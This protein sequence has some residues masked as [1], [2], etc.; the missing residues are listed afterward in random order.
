MRCAGGAHHVLLDHNGAEIVGTRMKAELGDVFTHRQPAGLDIFN[1][2][3]H[4]PA[5]GD[6]ADIFFWGGQVLHAADLCKQGVNVLKGPGD[7]GQEAL[8]FSRFFALYVADL[9][10]VFKPFFDGFHVTKHHGGRGGDVQL[11]CLVHDVK[12]FLSTA[13]S[14]GDQPANPIDQNLR[15]STRERVEPRFFQRIEHF[16]MGGFLQFGDMC[17]FGRTEGMEL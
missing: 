15:T 13:F 12:P 1:I 8:G 11:V 3:Q 2:G 10:E 17:H 16:F 14:L 6:H 7:K 5:E 4:D 9:H